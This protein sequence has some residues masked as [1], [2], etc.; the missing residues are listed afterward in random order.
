M[1]AEASLRRRLFVMII[2]PLVVVAAFAAVV[3]Y[4]LA[5]QMSQRLYDDTLMVVA[6]TI[7]RDVALSDGDILAE[8]LLDTLTTSLGDAIFYRVS[9]PG[10]RFLTGYSD[11]PVDVRPEVLESSGPLFFDAQYYGK[12]VRVVVLREYISDP[13]I[14]GWT[15]V[16]VW[17]T[18]AQR[19]QLSLQLLMQAILLMA[20]VITAAAV[21]VWLAINL[22][23]APL[24]GLREAIQLRSPEELRPIARPV[25]R[26]LKPIVE[27]MNSLFARLAQAFTERD[28]LI[29]NAAHQLRNPIAGIQAQ[30]EAAENATSEADL[31]R[32][33]AAVAQ[34][35]RHTSRLTQQ[36]L[37][38]EKAAHWDGP[39]C[40]SQVDLGEVTASVLEA[41]APGAL[42]R[43]VNVVFDRGAD[44]TVVVGEGIL[45]REAIDNLIDNALRYGCAN[46]GT[47][48]VDVRDN[49]DTVIVGVEDE[50]PG[51]AAAD[52]DRIFE[53][54]ERLAQSAGDGC[55]LGLAIVRAIAERHNG[56]V[57]LTRR[58][59]GARFELRFPR[60]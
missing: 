21:L 29:S 49:P 11:A 42:R 27:A 58:R 48:R 16:E 5:E 32:R 30:A 23:L 10:G 2:G 40:R 17:Q 1:K 19:E 12:P 28:V 18:L 51:I 56:S 47:L 57:V 46:G 43:G 36:L 14:G 53:R 22:G 13:Q 33:V 3:R 20:V 26:E 25:P 41:H 60:G 8:T 35:A 34:A 45:L 15:T 24:T 37:A 59:P 31:R 7:S 4:H 9:G 38:F 52:V 50:G 55:G 54:F 44:E 6:L 39:A